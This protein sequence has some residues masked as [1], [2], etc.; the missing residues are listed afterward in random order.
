MIVIVFVIVSLSFG[1]QV[2]GHSCGHWTYVAFVKSR[3]CGVKSGV[4]H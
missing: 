1:E 2:T 3:R 4:K